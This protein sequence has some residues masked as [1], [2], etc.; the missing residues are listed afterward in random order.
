[1]NNEFTLP[2]EWET[3]SA[4]LISWPHKDSD[5]LYILD[6]VENTYK[7]LIAAISDFHDVVVVAPDISIP[8]EKL[9]SLQQ[10]NNIYFFQVP[11]N[12]T[13]IR[14]YGPISLINKNT[15]DVRLLDF[16]FNAWGLKFAANFDNLVNS[17]MKARGLIYCG[18]E[19]N[20]DFVLEG[21]AIESDGCGTVLTTS[22]CQL[23]P[24]RNAS[25]N[26]EEIS[27]QLK[28][29]LNVDRIL[30]LNHGYLAGDDTD[31]HIDTLVRFAPND[32]LV[33]VSCNDI[34]DEHFQELKLMEDELKCFETSN[35]L[36]YNLVAL[37]LPDPVYDEEGN[38]LPATYANFLVT[39]KA[40]FMPTYRSPQKDELAMKIL[41]VVF[42]RKVV[43]VD[44]MDLIKQHGSLHCATMQCDRRAL[45]I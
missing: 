23:S 1:M 16:C 28:K 25:L 44:C 9:N 26:K 32:T 37:P 40:V 36:P 18:L 21:G 4:I 17:S 30:W 19:N 39:N 14:D 20:R 11:T 5:W 43:G 6:D 33:Y 2:A 7:E 41:E 22:Y 35:S 31:S 42:E 27:N 3:D 8:K 34:N 38:R 24:N 15:G 10:R 45:S 12:D 29:R 13:W